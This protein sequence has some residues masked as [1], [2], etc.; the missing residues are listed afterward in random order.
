MTLYH[1]G[2]FALLFMRV[3]R[4]PKRRGV[5]FAYIEVINSERALQ[6]L[7]KLYN[8]ASRFLIRGSVLPGNSTACFRKPDRPAKFKY[9][10]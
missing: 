4:V 7:I 9:I 10:F 8:F 1:S 3:E 6:N 2:S 5:C